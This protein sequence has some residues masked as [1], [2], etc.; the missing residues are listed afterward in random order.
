MKYHSALVIR[1]GLVLILLQAC[2]AVEATYRG[3][4]E[5]WNR[6]QAA[7]KIVGRD[8]SFDVPACGTVTESD[9]VLN[10]YDIEDA[11]GRFVARHGGGGSNPASVTPAYEVVTS[12]GAVYSDL[13]P[14]PSPLPACQGIVQGQIEGTPSSS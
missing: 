12:A 1:I 7:I 9:F 5:V 8:A 11:Q 6:T 13:N 4:I 3:K 14:P 2:S 10:R